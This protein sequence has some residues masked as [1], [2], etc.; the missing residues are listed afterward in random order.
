[1]TMEKLT[2]AAW[3]RNCL[4]LLQEVNPAYRIN[5]EMRGRFIELIREDDS[6]LTISHNFIK[7]R[8]IYHYSFAL[9]FTTRQTLLLRHCMLAGSRFDHNRSIWRQFL[10]DVGLFRTDMGYPP[11]VWSFGPWR[12]N[13]MENLRRGLRVPEEHLLPFYRE[14]LRLG[15]AALLALFDEAQRIVEK[16][17]SEVTAENAM[18]I[19]ESEGSRI[20]AYRR[21]CYSLDAFKIAQGGCCK[22]EYGPPEPGFVIE[23]VPRDVIVFSQISIFLQERNRLPE[24][25]DIARKL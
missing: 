2:Q 14:Q 21:E 13:T 7:I 17:P 22:F 23:D 24:F 25:A 3:S 5:R 1:M 4:E 11:G 18:K 12:S 6:G 10:D 20:E 8:D 16:L 15:K 19:L 9:L